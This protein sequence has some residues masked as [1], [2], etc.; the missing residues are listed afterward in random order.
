MVGETGE[1]LDELNPSGRVQVHG[2]IWNAVSISGKIN[3][4]EQVRVTGG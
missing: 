3:N 2:E 4:G 1:A